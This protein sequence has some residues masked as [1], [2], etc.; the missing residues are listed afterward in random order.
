MIRPSF[1]N[2]VAEALE[3]V[4]DPCSIGSNAPI[5]ILD[6]GLIQGWSM[7][8]DGHL[9]V[10]MCVTSACCT[11]APN[12]VR[13]AEEVLTAIPGVRSAHVE[14]DPTIFW[15]PASMTEKGRALLAARRSASLAATSV[16]PQQWRT[17]V[18]ARAPAG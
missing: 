15:T 10:K 6:M 17:Q 12:I 16:K 5:S 3:K 9:E 8:E 2:E 7:G 18:T 13:G 1:D 14:I 11:M 4:C